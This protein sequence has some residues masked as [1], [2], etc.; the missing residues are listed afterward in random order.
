M[1]LL[2]MPSNL[3][4]FPLDFWTRG[5]WYLSSLIE[6]KPVSPALEVQS[7]R[8]GLLGHSPNLSF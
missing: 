1:E 6:I 2:K 7:L 8:T 5:I 3:S 4:F